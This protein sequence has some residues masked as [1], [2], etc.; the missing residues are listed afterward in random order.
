MRAMSFAAIITNGYMAAFQTVGY[1]W[2]ETVKLFL[3]M[4]RKY[5]SYLWYKSLDN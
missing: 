5:Y 2:P 4:V 3:F 1:K